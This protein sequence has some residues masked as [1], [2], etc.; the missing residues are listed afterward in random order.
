MDD[1]AKGLEVSMLVEHVAPGRVLQCDHLHQYL[2]HKQSRQQGG[3]EKRRPRR[4]EP[5]DSR[6][7]RG[8]VCRGEY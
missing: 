4:M 7:Q 3:V 6:E 2:Q 8:S 5:P 1:L